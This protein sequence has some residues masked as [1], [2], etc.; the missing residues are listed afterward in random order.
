MSFIW[1]VADLLR[2]DVRQH[3]FGQYILP[4]VVLRRLDCVL[5]PTKADVIAKAKSLEGKVTNVDPIL[6]RVTGA[7]FYN[8]SPLNFVDLLNDPGN[9]GKN[10]R[11]YVSG[12]SADAADVLDKYKL[13]DRI[14]ALDKA[15]LLYQ[16]VA[17]FADIN[18]HPKVVPNHSMGY[19]FEE[20]LRRF[21]EMQNE[22][23]GEHFTPR[24]VIQLM[25]NILFSEDEKALGGPA[26]VRTML[27][28]ACGTGGMLSAAQ[29]HMH[30][31]NPDGHLEVYGQ[32]LNPETW[33]ICRSDMLIKGENPENIVLGNS[34]TADGH[35]GKRFDYL[36]ANPPFGVDWKKYADPIQAE[37]ANEGMDGRFGAG[38]PRVSDGSFLFL[39]HMISKMKPVTSSGGGSRLAIVFS[40]SPLFSGAAE[41]GE[42]NIRRWIIENDWL[43]AVVA[44]PDQLFYNTGISTYFWVITNR[45]AEDRKGKVALIDARGA[46]TKMRKSLGNKRNYF[47]DGTIDELTRLYS[48]APQ[49][50][51]DSGDARVKVLP[52]EAFGFH[53]ITVEQPLRRRW[54]ITDDVLASFGESK[55]WQKF[56]T[57]TLTDSADKSA[58]G[59]L[60]DYV[61]KEYATDKE[62]IAEATS[63]LSAAAAKEL[64]KLAAVA[65]PDAPIIT[66]RKGNALPDPDL[67]DYENVPLGEDVDEYLEREVHPYAPEAWIDHAK[68]KTGY[69]IPLTRHF[70]VYTPPRP[71]ADLDKEIAE[72]EARIRELLGGLA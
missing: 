45:K 24:E 32:E 67:R 13:G 29:E 20:L 11:S 42:S 43:E 65:D 71:V 5:E 58:Q 30:D 8:T 72:R 6:F 60:A 34:F 17:R 36:L 44:L 68:T 40:G 66:D 16:V 62:L 53:R 61:G 39:Q 1:S 47:T 9:I 41:S 7:P 63:V 38:L 26:P 37:A 69:E 70:Y 14:T 10:L 55:A 18:L 19:I 52:N 28:P 57:T 25:V 23:A 15:G 59:L 22:T 54:V 33:A 2:G 56:A 46:A 12:F 21:S 64:A 4:F 49:L 51:E 35:T 50:A 3:E 48:D 31:L 27:D